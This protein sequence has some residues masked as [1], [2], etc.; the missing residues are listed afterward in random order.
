MPE[1]ANQDVVNTQTRLSTRG[2][3]LGSPGVHP[4][5]IQSS[6]GDRLFSRT[7]SSAYGDEHNRADS[8]Q[9]RAQ[10][11]LARTVSR[12]SGN[13]SNPDDVFSKPA[14]TSLQEMPDEERSNG[15]YSGGKPV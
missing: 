10:P 3:A 15:C 2:N 8:R 11:P 1:Y 5:P 9:S 6:R 12:A 7:T 14:N 13:S 4:L